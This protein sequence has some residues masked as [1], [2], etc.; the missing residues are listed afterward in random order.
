MRP[1]WKKT[2]FAAM[3]MISAP[4]CSGTLGSMDSRQGRPLRPWQVKR[5]SRVK[6]TGILKRVGAVDRERAE[7]IRDIKSGGIMGDMLWD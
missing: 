3:S 4:G 6:E 7:E 1:E 5:W 2:R